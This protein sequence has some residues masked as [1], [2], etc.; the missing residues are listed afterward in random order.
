MFSKQ[1]KSQKRS[2]LFFFSVRIKIYSRHSLF[3]GEKTQ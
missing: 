1:L 2:L 3:S